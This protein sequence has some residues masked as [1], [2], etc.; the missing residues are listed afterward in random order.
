MQ[1]FRYHKRLQLYMIFAGAVPVLL[2]SVGVLAYLY[3]AMET[4][5]EQRAEQNVRSIALHV[6]AELDRYRQ[7][8][9]S[10]ADSEELN[11]YLRGGRG[12]ATAV[13]S[14]LF[15]L[16]RGMQ[17]EA[18]LQIV[19]A[20]GD[21]IFS[22]GRIM[23]SSGYRYHTNWGAFRQAQVAEES[24][25]VSADREEA[26]SYGPVLTVCRAIRQNGT[27]LG[28]IL[29]DMYRSALETA[30]ASYDLRGIRLTDAHHYVF[31]TMA[32]DGREGFVPEITGTGRF[33]APFGNR[34]YF[35]A[36]EVEARL[37]YYQ[38]GKYGIMAVQEHTMDW[39]NFYLLRRIILAFDAMILFL[40]VL[41]FLPRA[42]R[43]LLEIRQRE[44]TLRLAQIKELEEQV[45]PHFIYNTLD[46]I[47]WMAKRGDQ[48]SVARLA[49]ALGRL[50]RRVL[51]KSAFVQVREEVEMLE[52]YLTIQQ[53]RFSGRVQVRIDI[54]EKLHD[55]YLPKLILQPVLE[56]ALKHG[57]QDVQEGG[58]IEISGRLHEPYM[59][60]TIRD[61]GCGMDIFKIKRWLEEGVRTTEEHVGLRNVHLR[62]KINGD[63]SCG[64]SVA[65]V[66]PHGTQ[67]S[68]RLIAWREVPEL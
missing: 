52:A 5:E 15:L 22:T 3:Q 44:E 54:P 37:Y 58:R 13:Y 51:G 31:F 63:S 35:N 2:L 7:I 57:L 10:V 1:A 66:L 46:L 33:H 19:S 12:D 38:A 62:A 45:K 48:E 21:V 59:I 27:I 11:A 25:V 29:L 67:V 53:K 64:V 30:L 17:T 4:T 40:S 55:C 39:E 61:N 36:E 60:F 41:F 23:Y 8:T 42:R 34:T 9:D 32:P 43:L 50:L 47:K 24:V 65:A 56:N 26:G 18:G 6:E 20:S 49:V 28:Y 16:M 68:I 14:Q